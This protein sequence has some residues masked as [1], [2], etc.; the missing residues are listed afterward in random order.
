MIYY[1]FINDRGYQFKT[2]KDAIDCAQNVVDVLYA[3]GVMTLDEDMQFHLGKFD[4]DVSDD[5][6]VDT[7]VLNLI[8]EDSGDV[9]DGRG[10]LL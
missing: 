6:P 7:F 5:D 8:P 1:D 4:D 3:D 10:E 2:I 9:A